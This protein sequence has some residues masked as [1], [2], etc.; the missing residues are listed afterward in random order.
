MTNVFILVK[1]EKKT[2][3]RHIDPNGHDIY[4]Y[5]CT[6]HGSGCQSSSRTILITSNGFSDI[7]ETARC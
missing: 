6:V 5:Y 7:K 2:T 4:N 1:E 3:S